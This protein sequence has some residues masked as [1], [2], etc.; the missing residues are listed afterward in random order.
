MFSLFK[1][2]CYLKIVLSMCSTS[3]IYCYYF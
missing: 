2:S 1:V 3:P